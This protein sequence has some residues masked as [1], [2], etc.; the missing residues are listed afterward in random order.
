MS[1]PEKMLTARNGSYFHEMLKIIFQGCV[2][3]SNFIPIQ[4]TEKSF[5]SVQEGITFQFVLKP[6]FACF[7]DFLGLLSEIGNRGSFL[8]GNEAKASNSSRSNDTI[9]AE[10]DNATNIYATVQKVFCGRDLSSEEA[11]GTLF[12]GSKSQ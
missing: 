12:G 11:S 9:G 1:T 2:N 4:I 7:R 8:F 10:L 3:F 5:F 6:F